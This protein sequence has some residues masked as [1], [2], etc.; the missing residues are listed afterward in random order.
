MSNVCFL[1]IILLY[2]HNIGAIRDAVRH[3]FDADRTWLVL[4]WASCLDSSGDS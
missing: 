2:D 4:V 1:G 3:F